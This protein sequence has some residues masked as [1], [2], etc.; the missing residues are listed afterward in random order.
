MEEGL[1]NIGSETLHFFSITFYSDIRQRLE[2]GA[3]ISTAT[4]MNI[5][6]GIISVSDHFISFL[7]HT[8]HNT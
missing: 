8:I 4:I 2:L 3:I 1:A 7:H 5:P 6:H